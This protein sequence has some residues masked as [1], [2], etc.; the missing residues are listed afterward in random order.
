VVDLVFVSVIWV[1]IYT[2]DKKKHVSAPMFT[3]GFLVSSKLKICL[4]FCVVFFALF[5]FIIFLVS[6]FD[7]VSVLPILDCP[8]DFF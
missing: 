4:V 1:G 6:K 5:I 3:C 2:Q 7:C 8:L